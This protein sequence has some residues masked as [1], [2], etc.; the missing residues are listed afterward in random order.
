MGSLRAVNHGGR[1]SGS[2]GKSC[3]PLLKGWAYLAG[4]M[5]V[6]APG[7]QDQQ[8]G[9]VLFHKLLTLRKDRRTH[10]V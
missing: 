4:D 3:D 2:R 6:P 1:G 5:G 7:H 10:T 8:L 9:C